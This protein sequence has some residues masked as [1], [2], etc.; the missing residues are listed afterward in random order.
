MDYLDTF[1][2]ERALERKNKAVRMLKSAITAAMD[3]PWA[4]AYWISPSGK[5]LPLDDLHIDEI[6]KSPETF[7]L[8]QQKIEET[9][10]KYHETLGKEGEAR[11][12]LMRDIIKD[13]WIRIRYYKNA[14][15]YSIQVNTLDKDV[16][17]YLWAWA[18]GLLKKHGGHWN[19]VRITELGGNMGGW[20][21]NMQD[22]SNDKLLEAKEK[23][24][25]ERCVLRLVKSVY[26][27]LDV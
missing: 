22:I 16:K 6:I 7:G 25:Q 12:E 20:A 15:L 9:Y 11:E 18:S 21:G 1:L 17:D 13:G 5:L 14:A 10:E 26:E 4:N 24:E 23:N 3:V 19:N 2:G 27:I 8:T